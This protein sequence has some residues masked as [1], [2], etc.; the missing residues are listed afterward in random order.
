MSHDIQH[1]I[2]VP[3]TPQHNAITKRMN[4]TSMEKIRYILSQAKLP[5]KFWDEALRTTVD[6]INLS[7]CTTLDGDIV[8]HVWLEKDISCKNLSV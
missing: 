1:E 5:K 8:E 3:G 7:P 2:T 6:M 4:R